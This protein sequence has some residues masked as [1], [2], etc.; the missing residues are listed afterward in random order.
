[1]RALRLKTSSHRFLHTLSNISETW[2]THVGPVGDSKF[3]H[4]PP[5]R[6]SAESTEIDGGTVESLKD[7][8]NVSSSALPIFKHS[9]L[10][11]FLF[12]ASLDASISRA[13]SK[14]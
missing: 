11:L 12:P 1:V 14:G 10:T 9:K 7:N 3:R 13:L 5:T 4:S 8:L 6:T 2:P